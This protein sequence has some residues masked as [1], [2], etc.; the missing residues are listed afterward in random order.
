MNNNI[1]VFL[2][3]D[4]NYAPLVATTMASILSNT[5]SFI[6]FYIL[7]GGITSDNV[8]KIQSLK[9]NFNNFSIEFIKIDYEECFKD[10][11][12]AKRLTKA[13][14]SRLL[15]PELKTPLN[16]AIYLDADTLLTGNIAEFYNEDLENY[17]LGAV[18]EEYDQYIGYPE[19]KICMEFSDN[20]KYF[21]SG[22]LLI[23]CQKWRQNR[24]FDKLVNIE[25]EYK[26]RKKTNDQD[27][28]NKCF[29]NNYKILP[30]KYNYLTGN[31]T[32]FKNDTDII[33]R[34]MVGRIRPW[35]INE[36]AQTNLIQNLKE[37]WY[38]AKMTPFYE[39]LDAKTHDKQQQALLLRNA[40][41][42]EF[43]LKLWIK[44]AKHR[45][46]TANV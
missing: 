15:I 42:D 10:F 25:K 24:I 46:E 39:E 35:Q 31:F 40:Q 18:W 1:P 32:Y 22:V 17:A 19:R 45:M 9:N 26:N 5:K 12:P 33:I 36:N 7:D 21:N 14:F 28:L 34:H 37:F 43:Y 8:E 2:S 27:I 30:R 41:I 6:E 20:H 16:R 38:Y 44:R 13:A 29:D 11:T 23:D 4:N 3:S